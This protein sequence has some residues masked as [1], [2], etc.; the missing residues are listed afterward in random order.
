MGHTSSLPIVFNSLKEEFVYEEIQITRSTDRQQLGENKIISRARIFNTEQLWEGVRANDKK[1]VYHLIVVYQAD[2]NAVHEEE[3]SPSNDSSIS[4]NPQ[5]ENE[6]RCIDE[7]LDGCSLLHL[8]FQ[9]VDIDMVELLLQHGAN[10]NACDS[11]GNIEE[12]IYTESSKFV[13]MAK[14]FSASKIFVKRSNLVMIEDGRHEQ[15]S[16]GKSSFQKLLATW[17]QD[18]FVDK[19]LYLMEEM[20]QFVCN[21]LRS[22]REEMQRLN[23]PMIEGLELNDAK[24]AFSYESDVDRTGKR[25]VVDIQLHSGLDIQGFEDF[26]T[27]PPIEILKKAGLITDASASQPTKR[28]RTV[29]FDTKTFEEQDREKT[30]STV[31]RRIHQKVGVFK[32]GNVPSKDNVEE[33]AIVTILKAKGKKVVGN[34]DKSIGLES[35]D[36]TMEDVYFD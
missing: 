2:V 3:E 31:S 32:T 29:R 16:W 22:T 20:P 34:T 11:R 33:I 4:F 30:P 9:T 19:Q 15:V 5:S 21:N 7:F 10:I 12:H 28:R 13:L 24:S 17:R 14:Y 26:S 36:D 6:Q 8:A 23:L 35:D 25:P 27:I 18:F 1:V